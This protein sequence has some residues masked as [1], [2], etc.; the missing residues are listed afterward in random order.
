MPEHSAVELELDA[1]TRVSGYWSNSAAN[2]ELSLSL[3]NEGYVEFEDPQQIAVT[4]V[5]DGKTIDHCG[6]ETFL[7]L[8]DGFGPS[9][10]ETLTL[11]V[12][13]GAVTL[14]M[15]Y[16]REEPTVLD[17]DVP[18]RILGVA[19]DVWECFS[20]RSGIEEG[21]GGWL[22]DTVVKWDQTGPVKVWA[23]GRR[24]YILVLEEVLQEVSSLLNL[25]FQWVKSKTEAD[26]VAYVGVSIDRAKRVGVYCEHSWGCARWWPD[27]SGVVE[28]ATIGVWINESQW[29][30]ELGLLEDQIKHTTVHEVLHAL[31]PI[32][33]RTEPTSVM[34]AKGLGLVT[35]SSM[36]EG[37]IRLH[38]HP[39]VRPGMTMPEVEEL[40][41]FRDE[42]LDPPQL[43]EPNG[44]E[45]VRSA[46]A[47]LQEAGSASF[48]IRG[49]WLDQSCE[50]DF[51]WM[52]YEMTDLGVLRANLVHL[53]D[54]PGEFYLIY[55]EDGG[56]VEVWGYSTRGWQL[57]DL[58]EIYARTAWRRGRTEFL[59]LLTNALYFA[60]RACL[61]K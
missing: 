32:N 11:R 20:D 48:R 24:D 5:H 53:Y 37:L 13:M 54:V 43:E 60:S 12:P 26:L 9:A 7:S 25:E 56:E 50:G 3:R 22:S 27:Y 47:A 16:G 34:S 51:G 1:E 35:L 2:L 52:G 33:H 36:D 29:L 31:A 8:P 41:V 15:D 23:T 14:R 55:S 40:I 28:S 42:L 39:L 19:R 61:I 18:Q 45:M 17:V 21:C 59:E 58:E 6:G 30:M 4:C 44:Y 38:S 49:S 57:V 46:Y 10:A